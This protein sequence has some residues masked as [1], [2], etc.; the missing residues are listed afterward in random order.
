MASAVGKH[1]VKWR[2]PF[3][4]FPVGRV[5]CLGSLPCIFCFFFFFLLGFCLPPPPKSSPPLIPSNPS[6]LTPALLSHPSLPPSFFPSVS[7]S[8]LS[9]CVSIFAFQVSSSLAFSSRFHMLSDIIW[10]FFPLTYLTLYDRFIH[11][12]T[13]GAI[14][15]L[16]YGWIISHFIYG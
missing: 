6:L 2:A 16:F 10:Y 1:T 8:L 13:N 14:S 3:F 7:I 5:L 9:T 12:S 11:I 4:F 15:F